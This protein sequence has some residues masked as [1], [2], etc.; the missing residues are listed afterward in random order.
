MIQNIIKS[1]TLVECLMLPITFCVYPNQCTV[2]SVK[3][4]NCMCTISRKLIQLLDFSLIFLTIFVNFRFVTTSFFFICNIWQNIVR[5][6]WCHCLSI[7]ALL[8]KKIMYYTKWTKHTSCCTFEGAVAED[9]VL[10]EEGEVKRTK[11][12]VKRR[13]KLQLKTSRTRLS[14]RTIRILRQVQVGSSS[15]YYLTKASM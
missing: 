14:R 13:R 10:V 9:V 5:C 7:G 11:R 12:K 15:K 4:R 1:L 2:V 3:L 8:V 6:H